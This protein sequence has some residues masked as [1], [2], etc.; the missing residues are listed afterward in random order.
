VRKEPP[1]GGV[2]TPLGVVLGFVAL[3][4]WLVLIWT[5]GSAVGLEPTG[6]RYPP[7]GQPL[8]LLGTLVLAP[9]FEELLYRERLLLALRDAI[10]APLGITLSS[11][12]FALPHL[13]G[14]SVLGTFV[15]GLFLGSAMLWTRS[16]AL[17][18]GIHAGLNLA[19]AACGIP[20]TRWV[21]H[22]VPSALLS[23]ALLWLAARWN[24]RSPGVGAQ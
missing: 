17:C 14:W 19:A 8:M 11:V 24:R 16:I 1:L 10:G 20:P 22:W 2:M 6:R 7:G 3:S 18:I 23:G 13:Q 15:V 21:L 9:F 5:L 4:F 12:C